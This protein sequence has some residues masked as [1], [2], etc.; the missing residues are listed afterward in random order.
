M[1]DDWCIIFNPAAGRRRAQ[2]RLR[3]WQSELGDRVQF[4]PTERPGHAETLARQAAEEGFACVAAAGGDGT[5]HEVLNGILAAHRPA[6]RL[7]LLPLGSANDFAYSL[8]P[9]RTDLPVRRVIDIG[10]VRAPNRS[11]YFGCAAGF[12]FG[13]Q[14]TVESRQLKHLQGIA[15]YGVAALRALYRSFRHPV[16]ELT[17]DDE[18]AWRTPTLLLSVLNG[19]REGNFPLAPQAQLD[20]GRLDFLH[21]GPLSRGQ[22][23]R[24]LPRLSLWGPPPQFPGVRQGRC[25]RIAIASA[26]PLIGHVDGEFFCLPEDD[27]RGLEI[28]VHPRKLEVDLTWASRVRRRS[29][30]TDRGRA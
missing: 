5:V 6:V 25:R 21:A 19:R 18:P 27:L 26:E 28:I 29:Q 11:R 8:E 30:E 12:G 20:D 23:L 9:D 22:V 16:W 1:T 15:L 4:R 14:V 13:A 3:Q 7:G 2:Q 10:E 24:L 17:I